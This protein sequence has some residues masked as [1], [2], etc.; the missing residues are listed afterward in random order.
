VWSGGW[1]RGGGILFIFWDESGRGRVR[2]RLDWN[3][4]DHRFSPL[5]PF[6]SG[7]RTLLIPDFK[8]V[9]VYFVVSTLLVGTRCKSFPL[10]Y[11]RFNLGSESEYEHANIYFA[12]AIANGK[13]C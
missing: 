11:R 12:Y 4:G 13:L 9:R 2:R 6:L 3:S 7:W 5:A 8:S 1:S 10:G